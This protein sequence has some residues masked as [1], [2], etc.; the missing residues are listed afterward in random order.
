MFLAQNGILTREILEQEYPNLLNVKQLWLNDNKLRE[1]DENT[2]KDLNLL[3]EL[4][5]FNNLIEEIEPGIFDGLSNLKQLRLYKNKLRKIEAD[6]F[7]ELN[8]V[9]KL[10]LSL[11]QIE[12]IVP[13]LFVNLTNL[14]KLE[15]HNNKL[16]KIE[17]DTFKGLIQLEILYL[18]KNQI[19]E[20]MPGAFDELRNV[21]VIN[22]YANNL[23]RLSR[24]TLRFL[25]SSVGFVDLRENNFTQTQIVSF[26]NKSVLDKWNSGAYICIGDIY[27][28]VAKIAD[29]LINSGGFK[30][31]FNKFLSQFSESKRNIFI[32]L[33]ISYFLKN[34]NFLNTKGFIYFIKDSSESSV[35]GSL[36]KNHS[37]R[38]HDQSTLVDIHDPYVGKTFKDRYLVTK[39]LGEG[40]FGNV[41]LVT[42]LSDKYFF[43]LN[44]SY[45]M[46]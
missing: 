35:S 41:Y 44:Y 6:T 17:A 4:Y 5:L 1:I 32:I 25:S 2:F 16:S 36:T 7:K 9:E 12:E 13:R 45:Q 14:K 3:E 26:Y 15:F 19:E 24:A 37:M 20:I 39:A 11:N 18:Q 31:D 46:N 23:T 33:F 10:Y 22:L 38:E 30:S 28:P 27:E 42:D 29:I 8:L 40:A 34:Y 21:R 43:L